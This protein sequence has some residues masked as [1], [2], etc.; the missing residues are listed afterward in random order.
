MT[1]TFAVN[2]RNDIYI[3]DDSNLVVLDGL[4]AILQACETATKAQLGEMIFAVNQ[5]IPNFQAI[6]VG[7]PNYK[8]W[9]SYLRATLLSVSGV[10]EV[11]SIE[12][13]I[14]ENTLKYTATISTSFG[15][16][17]LNG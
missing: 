14:V 15:I 4:Q 11:K 5:G 1:K 17:V 3:G 7:A 16:G 9:Q 12:L 6:W 13:S 10:L 2:A 8:I